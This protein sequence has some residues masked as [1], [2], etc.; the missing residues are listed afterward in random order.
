[1]AGPNRSSTRAWPIALK[2]GG[3]AELVWPRGPQGFSLGTSTTPAPG[4]W[5]QGSVIESE[6]AG[7][8]TVN[9][10]TQ[11]GARRFFR[12]KR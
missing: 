2:P 5:L 3:I 4:S 1:M 11:G 10:G 6:S 12:L 8:I 9:P 7:M